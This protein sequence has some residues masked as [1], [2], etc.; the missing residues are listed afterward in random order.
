MKIGFFT[1]SYYPSNSGLVTSIE[2]FRDNIEKFG[3]EVYVFA[4][5]Y[6][7]YKDLNDR[8][9]RFRSIKIIQ[10]PEVR[11]ASPFFPIKYF[12]KASNLNLDI[13]HIH[14]PFAMGFL[15]K[16]IAIQ[17]KKPIIYTHHTQYPEYAKFYLK[18]KFLLPYLAHA[19]TIWFSNFSDA[20]IA[21]SYKVKNFLQ[22]NGVKKKIYILPS[23]I[24]TKIFKKSEKEKQQ[25]KKELKI[26]SDSKILLFVGRIGKEKNIDFLLKMFK[27]LL[28]K[29][30]IPVTLLIVGDGSILKE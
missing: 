24:N 7:G 3:N 22:K 14:T 15:G 16:Y 8:V 25:I 27:K 20:V 13:I 4:P 23:G 29:T 30:K 9:L 10:K 19:L 18:E 11:F 12:K 6:K 5:F 1:D 17:N 26:P 28:E 21:P 2:S